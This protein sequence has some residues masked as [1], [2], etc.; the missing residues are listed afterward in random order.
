MTARARNAPLA[1]LVAVVCG[2]TRGAGRGVARAFGE[3]GAVVYCTGRS[4]RHAAS[5]YQR[6]ETVDE[7]A[8]LVTASGGLG[9]P[10]RVDHT[11]ESEVQALFERVGKEHKRLDAVVDSV[12][13]EDKV[14]GPW[15]PLWSTD[16]SQAAVALSQGLIT[17][18]HTAKYAG[19]L[20]KKRKHGL[21]VQVTGADYPFYGGNVVHDLVM[22]GH[23]GLAFRIAEELRPYRV[24]SV[25][26]TP[27]FLRSESMLQ[28]FGVTEANWRDGG[29]QDKHFL[30]SE[31]PLLIGR[32]IVALAKDP[33]RMR[34]SG[35][36]TSSWE[37][38]KEYGLVDYD[39]HNPDWGGNWT[40]AVMKEM[41]PMRHGTVRQIEWLER[42]AGRLRGYVGESPE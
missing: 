13:G 1:P 40:R 15:T 29:A 4:T 32:A 27:G 23:K 25:A 14:Y 18:V 5:P 30:H 21:M 20:F 28:H 38:A 36:L 22:L 8:E 9:I 10:V 12:A 2:A 7:T 39:G 26:I 37:V 31:S 3:A 41:P 33:Q 17:R 19:A 24:A 34:W 35:H 6:P 16:V 42:A 11:V